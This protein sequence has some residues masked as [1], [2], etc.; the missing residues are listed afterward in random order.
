MEQSECRKRPS[1]GTPTVAVTRRRPL[2][3][4]RVPSNLRPARERKPFVFSLRERPA[5][6][7]FAC[8]RSA[9]CPL[10]HKRPSTLPTNLLQSIIARHYWRWN[11]SA[12]RPDGL[13]TA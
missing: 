1:H 6:T 7:T 12:L 11:E 8:L 3:P 10:S 13:S 5:S 9:E 4:T 2:H